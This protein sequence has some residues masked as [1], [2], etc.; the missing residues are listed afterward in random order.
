[1]V[2]KD[3]VLQIPQFF[4]PELLKKNQ[5]LL[6]NAIIFENS[7]EISYVCTIINKEK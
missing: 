1:M 3:Y 4:R 2:C 7:F 5:M 6:C